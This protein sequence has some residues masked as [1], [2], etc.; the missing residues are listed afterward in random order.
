MKKVK[1]FE[2]LYSIDETGNVYSHFKNRFLKPQKNTSGYLYVHLTDYNGIGKWHFVHRLVLLSNGFTINAV[3]KEVNHK[4]NNKLNNQVSN[5]EWVTH[6]E[7]IELSYKFA[8]KRGG[9][10]KGFNHDQ[11]TKDKMSRAKNKPVTY[12]NTVTGDEV[13]K[14]SI[15]EVSA[16]LGIYRKAIYRAIK[17]KK[18]YKEY[19][20]SFA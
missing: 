11:I 20:F 19:I 3:G 1:G 7:N 5:L 16:E 4:D 15:A 9:R 10:K 17:A 8:R 14:G 13:T 18:Q 12:I 2:D 6:Q